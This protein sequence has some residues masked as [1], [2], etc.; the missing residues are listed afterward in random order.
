[1]SFRSYCPSN[2]GGGWIQKCRTSVKFVKSNNHK[3]TSGLSVPGVG[4][5][6]DRWTGKEPL[7][8]RPPAGITVFDENHG[9]VIVPTFVSLNDAYRSRVP[10]FDTQIAFWV[11]NIS[12]EIWTIFSRIFFYL[13]P[14][15]YTS[16][17]YLD[18]TS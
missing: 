7:L 11:S 2:D 8:V 15:K 12:S 13:F 14:K 1:M 3:V 16:I 4:Y 17:S 5:R 10:S 9:K 18:T 6:C